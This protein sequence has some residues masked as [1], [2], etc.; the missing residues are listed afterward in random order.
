MVVDRRPIAPEAFAAWTSALRPLV[1][2]AGASFFEATTAIAFADFAARGADV[3]VIEVGL[4]G[5]LDCT[6]VVMPLVS[7]VTS[8]AMD[9]TEYL[10]DSLE[11]IAAEKAG[12][13]KAGCPF[14]IGERDPALADLLAAIARAVAAVPVVVPS[15][16]EYDGAL[17]LAGPHQRRNA[18]IAAC[19][20]DVLPDGL[21]PSVYDRTRAFSSTVV[22]G[23]FDRR[24][25][26][27]LDVAH[28]P[29][30]IETLLRGLD[31]TPLSRP[32]HALV[33][34]LGDKDWRTMLARLSPAVERLWVTT[35]PTAPDE[36]R[37]SLTEVAAAFPDAIV[38]PVFEK[39]LEGVQVG[40]ASVVVTGSFHTV[41]DAMARLPGFAPLG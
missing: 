36:R 40:A 22:P 38:E 34:V 18:A 11:R 15:D 19:V 3:A 4:G 16:R 31:A 1:E 25:S 28:N 7:A 23:R 33:G 27:L 20:L 37:W 17:G 12:I 10:G 8:V 13:A 9:H 30:G 41:G 24:G 39:A 29:A 6:N 21:R 32:L 2:Q 5:R 26:W 14:V 35:P